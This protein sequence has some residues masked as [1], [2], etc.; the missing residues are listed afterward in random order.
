MIFGVTEGTNRAEDASRACIP[1]ARLLRSVKPQSDRVAVPLL[2]CF[3]PLSF[4]KGILLS[5]RSSILAMVGPGEPS[6]SGA[7]QLIL[8][9]LLSHSWPR[10]IFR[11]TTMTNTKQ[12][13]WYQ[14]YLLGYLGGCSLGPHPR[15][16]PDTLLVVRRILYTFL[17]ASG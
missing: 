10:M 16:C 17:R 6:E 9:A 12:G 7:E 14:G 1:L 5:T 15:W 2:F 8:S 3:F 13:V 11:I 4:P